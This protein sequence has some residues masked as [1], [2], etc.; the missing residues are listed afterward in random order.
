MC[1]GIAS[2]ISAS[3]MSFASVQTRFRCPHVDDRVAVTVA[4]CR[5]AD[6]MHDG[7]GDLP[8]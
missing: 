5:Q 6:M 7:I 1:A 2:G 3:G 4:A 8:P